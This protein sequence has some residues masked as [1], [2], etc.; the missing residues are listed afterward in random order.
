MGC[1]SVLGGLVDEASALHISVSGLP[2]ALEEEHVCM[3]HEL[4]GQTGSGWFCAF[5]L[6]NCLQERGGG[7]GTLACVHC[8][9]CLC[10]AYV[11]GGLV[12]EASAPRSP[13]NQRLVRLRPASSIQRGAGACYDLAPCVVRVISVLL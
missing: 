3:A 12:D 10:R 6:L 9:C 1:T 13:T 11:L 2:T 4:V 5:G 8:I 7:V